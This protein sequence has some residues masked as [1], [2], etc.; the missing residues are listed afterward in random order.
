VAGLGAA[1]IGHMTRYHGLVLAVLGEL[2]A[3]EALLEEAARLA[4]EARFGP[5]LARALVERAIVLRRRNAPDDEQLAATLD[6]EGRALASDLGIA[7][8]EPA[9]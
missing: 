9:A 7:L 1:S 2:D 4:R 8:T 5:E 6:A 3:A